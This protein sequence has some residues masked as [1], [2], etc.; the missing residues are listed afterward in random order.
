VYSE[1]EPT[2]R[3]WLVLEVDSAEAGRVTSLLEAEKRLL[4]LQGKP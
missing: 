2:P 4:L 3:D 1:A